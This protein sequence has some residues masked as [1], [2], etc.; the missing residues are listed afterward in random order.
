MTWQCID[1]CQGKLSMPGSCIWQFTG[2]IFH[3]LTM[4][5]TTAQW[6]SYD[7][8]MHLTTDGAI[9]AHD[10]TM[11][12]TIGWANLLWS[13]STM[14]LTVDWAK[15]SWP[16]LADHTLDS[17]LGI[18]PTTWPCILRLTMQIFMTWPC[19]WQLTRQ[20][21]TVHLTTNWVNQSWL[22]RALDR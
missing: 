15:C 12:F 9:I 10:L 14:Y 17:W 1:N 22:D 4:H 19:N 2:Q 7:Q 6:I 21:L 18:S 16:D 3:S 5:L 8:T 11:H 13:F 20:I